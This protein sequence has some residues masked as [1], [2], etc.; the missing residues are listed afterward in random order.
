MVDHHWYDKLI[1][2]IMDNYHVPMDLIIAKISSNI[3]LIICLDAQG[4]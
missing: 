2:E 3:N 1:M 4:L